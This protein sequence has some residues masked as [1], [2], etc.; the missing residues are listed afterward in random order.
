MN[1]LIF[2]LLQ[3]VFHYICNSDFLDI[4]H[5]ISF[6]SLF[7]NNFSLR[8]INIS[9]FKKEY[10]KNTLSL[11]KLYFQASKKYLTAQTIKNRELFH[12]KFRVNA[13]QA[14]HDNFLMVNWLVYLYQRERQSKQFL[15]YYNVLKPLK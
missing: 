5:R 13:Q 6:Y 9:I 10:K 15:Y 8:R 11:Y 14:S 1:R 3:N 4:R 2:P 12:Q 7:L